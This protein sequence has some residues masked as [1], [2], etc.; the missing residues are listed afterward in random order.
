MN[1]PSLPRLALYGTGG[2]ALQ[3]LALVRAAANAG[4]PILYVRDDA[5]PDESFMGFPVV[6][7]AALKEDD[8]LLLV[9]ASG[10]VRQ[11]LGQRHAALVAG[12][13]TASTAIISPDAQLAPGAILCDH[14]IVEPLARIGVHFH[15]N[16]GSFIAHECVIG[17][18]VTFAPKV[19][20]NGNVHIGD[21][22]Y[23]GAGAIIRQGT[24]DKPLT[25]GAGAIVGMGAVVTKDVPPGAVVLGNPARIKE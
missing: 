17:D 1:S 24:P 15:A 14:V 12:S 13:L 3:T 19:C 8:Q 2:F 5:Q 18:Y 6:T 23:I 9:M 11:L 22:A 20:C 16:V 7:S 10:K 21:G 4:Q 25:I